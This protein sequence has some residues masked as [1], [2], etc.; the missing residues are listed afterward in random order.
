[1]ALHSGSSPFFFNKS[2][3]SEPFLPYPELTL[4]LKLRTPAT[5]GARD[6]S[7]MFFDDIDDELARAWRVLSGFC[8]V[9]NFAVES[10][11]RISTET[12]LD[13]M[14]SV[15][16]RLLDMR[17]EAGSSDEA[18][19]HG[20]LAY[21][22]SV[23]LPWK[24]LGIFYPHFTSAFR[25]CLGTLTS[26]HISSQLW[27]WLLMIGA[28]SVFDATDDQWLK[29]L[30]LLNLRLCEIDSWSKMQDL[31]KSFMWIGL[32]HDK[33]GKA[34]FELYNRLPGQPSA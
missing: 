24:Q 30:L 8:S 1:M 23:F 22:S 7:A 33:P 18:I 2:P 13:S 10:R 17:F 15:V 4:L 34:V 6:D 26:S 27:I 14:A 28:V 16:Y 12:F 20:L 9:I 29:P 5:T 11:Q 25:G 32:L 19:R 21:S 3:S 31:L